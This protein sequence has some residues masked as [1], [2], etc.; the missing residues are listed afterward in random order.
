MTFIGVS[1]LHVAAK[2]IES[3]DGSDGG[4]EV[5]LLYK[6]SLVLLFTIYI[7]LVLYGLCIHLYYITTDGHT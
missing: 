4:G 3:K 5:V 7:T 2:V 6:V 1:N